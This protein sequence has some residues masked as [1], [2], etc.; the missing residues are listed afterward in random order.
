MSI[1]QKHL[2]SIRRLVFGIFDSKIKITFLVDFGKMVGR[3]EAASYLT[4]HK[5]IWE[6]DLDELNPKL[7]YVD[8][9]SPRL[10]A[11]IKFPEK[12]DGQKL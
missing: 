6:I 2:K 12:L 5:K 10:R 4:L 11:I 3:T 9:P 1:R 8:G 7:L